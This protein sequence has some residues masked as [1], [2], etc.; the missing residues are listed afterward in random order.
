MIRTTY[1]ARPHL[2]A[3]TDTTRFVRRDAAGPGYS[4]CVRD[5]RTGYDIRQGTCDADD[6][7]PNVRV[8]ADAW[9]GFVY[10]FIEW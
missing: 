5:N 1:E 6:L 8:A 2:L 10:G 7:P 9:A 4:W 3:A